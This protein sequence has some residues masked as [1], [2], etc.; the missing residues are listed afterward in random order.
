MNC[1]ILMI[2]TPDTR[3][4][5]VTRLQQPQPNKKPKLNEELFFQDSRDK[6]KKLQKVRSKQTKRKVKNISVT[7]VQI[8]YNIFIDQCPYIVLSLRLIACGR[9]HLLNV[10]SRCGGDPFLSP[11]LHLHI[12]CWKGSARSRVQQC[13]QPIA[14]SSAGLSCP[15]RISCHT[16]S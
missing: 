5:A 4:P 3:K 13:G 15:G 12:S 8:Q 10:S 7:T 2:W 6:Y 14:Q 11:K 9:K 1:L 16:I